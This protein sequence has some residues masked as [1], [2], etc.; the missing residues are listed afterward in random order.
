[1]IQKRYDGFLSTPFLWKND[2][3]L[4]LT[5]FNTPSTKSTVFNL[6]INNKLR[7]GKYIEHFVLFELNTYDDIS[8]LAENIQIQDDKRTIGELDCLFLKNNQPVHLEIVYKFYLYDNSKEAN[9]IHCFI[10]PN[11]KDSLFEKVT[12]LKNKQLPLLHTNT[13]KPYLE[14]LNLLADNVKQYVYFK[15]QLFVPFSNQNIVLHTLNTDCIVGYYIKKQELVALKTSKF[16]IPCK[17]D[18][19]VIPHPNVK[20][21]NFDLFTVKVEDY[22]TRKFSPMCWVK[23]KNG[24]LNKMFVVWW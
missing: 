23:F 7:L 11:K 1:M 15:A 22:F 4:G 9:E 5:Q 16:F 13:C 18:W 21:M 19:L 12:K 3:V 8:V 6:S 20:W 14:A 24:K 10:G 17:K 2:A